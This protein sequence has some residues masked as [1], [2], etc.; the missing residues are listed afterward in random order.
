MVF[1]MGLFTVSFQCI[2]TGKTFYYIGLQCIPLL[3]AYNLILHANV[4][5]TLRVHYKPELQLSSPPSHFHSLYFNFN[6]VKVSNF[7]TAFSLT[8]I[9]TLQN[10]QLIDP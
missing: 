6:S 4:A 10:I 9:I 8:T 1:A 2:D 3:K 7:S 5:H